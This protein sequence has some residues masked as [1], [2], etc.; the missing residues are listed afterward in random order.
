VSS[1]S[2]TSR[3]RQARSFR[4]AAICAAAE[5]IGRSGSLIA[6]PFSPRTSGEPSADNT[7]SAVERPLCESAEP[8][9]AETA[10]ADHGRLPDLVVLVG[11]GRK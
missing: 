2:G 3:N 6:C 8:R 9:I 10:D 7:G 4:D 11:G 1:N 5:R